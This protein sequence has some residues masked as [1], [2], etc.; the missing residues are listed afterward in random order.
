MTT[1]RFKTLSFYALLM[2]GCAALTGMSMTQTARAQSENFIAGDDFESAPAEQTQPAAPI[3]GF[4]EPES[5]PKP[6]PEQ[7]PAITTEAPETPAETTPLQSQNEDS[8]QPPVKA[9]SPSSTNAN[10]PIEITADGSLE[11]HRN[12]SSFIAT[13]NA[14]AKQGDVSLAA[15]KLIADYKDGNGSKFEIWR[16]R[17]NES[18]RIQ[19]RD[20]QAFGD[21]ANYDISTGYAELTGNDL[22]LVSPDQTVT[23]RDKFEYWTNEGRLVA[24]GDASLTRVNEKGETN[25]LKA[26][27]LTAFM[28]DNAQGKRVLDR[29]EATGNVVIITPT[30][31]L[32][33][34]KGIYNASTNMAEITGNVQIKRGPNILE[35]T[36]ADVN[37]TTNVSRMF[38]GGNAKTR[39]RGVFYPNSEKRSQ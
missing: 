27:T 1:H 19:S 10:E 11:W 2:V 23:A 5:D 37:L 15:E 8:S 34:Q 6:N 16:V 3:T 32:S 30:E 7:I 24:I 38:G 13:K 22:K 29:L 18:V 4:G 21:Q 12:D 20:T 26:D 17:A 28:K 25:T 33:G 39:V 36:K 9:A 31:T 35:G 14:L